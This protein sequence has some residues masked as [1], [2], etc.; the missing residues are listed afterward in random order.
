MYHTTGFTRDRI[1]EICA[2]VEAGS[3]DVDGASWPPIL[4]LFDSVVVTLTYLRRNRV[5]AELAEAFGVSQSTISRAVAAL[6]PVLGRMLAG[7]VPIAEDLD[8]QTQYIVDGT[9]LHA[10]HGVIS[11]SCTPASTRPPGLTSRSPATSTDGC[12]DLRPGGWMPTRLGRSGVVRCRLHPRSRKLDR[13]QGLRR[14]RHDYPDQEA[15]VPGICWTGRRNSTP[16]S[17]RSG[18]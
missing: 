3:E 12:M 13:R 15:P 17:T 11:N 8:S 2:L 14:K 18:I 10:G 7:Y 6:T 9:L 16:P 5:Q 4:G 1:V